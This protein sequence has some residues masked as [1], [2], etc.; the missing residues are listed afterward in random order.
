MT[1][2]RVPRKLE[3]VLL[4][5][6]LLIAIIFRFAAFNQV[7]PGLH[8]DE[9]MDA[10][11]AQEIHGGAWPIYFEEGWGRE[12][13]YHYLVAATLNFIPD[14]TSALRCV[15]GLLGLIQLLAAYFLFRLLFGVPTALIGAAW[16]A[17]LFWTVSTSRAGLRNIT[18]TTLATLTALAFWWALT[19]IE[20]QRDRAI[21]RNTSR[22]THHVLRF[23]LAGIL[24]GLTLYTYQ[25][26]RV[27]P[28]IYLLFAAYLYWRERGMLKANWKAFAIFFI[29]ALIV[30]M[31][32][33]VFL[34]TH[35]GAETARAF[36]TE[37]IRALLQGDLSKM[38]E[39]TIATLKMFT[40]EGDP[41]ILYNLVGR[42]L[43]IGLGSLLFV[44]GLLVS[45]ARFRRPAYAFMLIWLVVTLLPNLV[46]APAPFFYRAIATQTPVA[47]M[48]AIATVAL[49]AWLAAGVA[50]GGGQ[51]AAVRAGAGATIMIA[52]LSLGQTAVTTWHDYFEVWGNAR[53]VRFQYSAAYT[54]IASA[55]KQA[56]DITPVALSGYFSEDADPIIFEQALN[57]S[58][59]TV[60]WFDAREALIAA[61]NTSAQRLALPS[62]TPLADELNVRFLDH[63]EPTA[64][65]KDFAIYPFAAD[66][67]RARIAA[68][69]CT[70]C[71]TRFNDQIELTGVEQPERSSRA[72]TVLPILTAWH[73]LSE[74][75][76]GSTAIFLH[77]LD[78][79]D[80]IVAQDDRLGVPR[81]TWQP[82]DEFVQVHR[83]NIENV[84]PGKY[85]LALGLYDRADNVRWAATD[86]SGQALGDRI[87]L[88]EI[89]VT[90]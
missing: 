85:R 70:A 1:E 57:G 27:V 69:S 68:W 79:R 19:K 35:P 24:L 13:L 10:K 21:E 2:V 56:Q 81:H 86:R 6:I 46:T 22:L 60:R 45:A 83:L 54:G 71:P 64:Q 90:P 42:P 37:P 17:V 14:P 50:R 34:L 87:I 11:L 3:A 73:V 43:F 32:L 67:F 61:A 36:Q 20:G 29:V 66:R 76:P 77:L 72:G 74:S 49:G 89:E 58:D 26:S 8:Y 80:Q 63:V 39:T 31:P 4:I 78:E 55:L 40:A 23:T 9:A 75:E 41:Q 48:P 28:L 59:V 18:L 84:P 82:G 5:A 47:A 53:D 33:I 16:I 62:Y 88:G 52:L 65:S 30:A 25:P 15:S 38:F 51:S 7:P 12:P 44:I